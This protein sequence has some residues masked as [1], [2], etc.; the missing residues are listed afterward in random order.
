MKALQVSAIDSGTVID[1]IESSQTL[2]VAEILKVPQEK[3]VVLVGTN[4]DS[5]ALGKKG[6]IKVSGRD[7][8]QQ[9]VN[10]IALI[11][12]DATVNII[13][14]YEVVKKFSV[15]IPDVIEGIV[16][17]FNPNCVTNHQ[18]LPTKF[19]VVE[20]KPLKLRCHHCERT[21]GSKDVQL[22]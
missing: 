9:D 22:I 18:G 21:L 6:I 14:D 8:T 13:K 20:R 1:H 4:L 16:K 7:L 2:N 19:H 17:C 3:G 15:R 5:K 11:A 12:P 10:K